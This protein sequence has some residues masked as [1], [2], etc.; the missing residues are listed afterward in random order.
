MHSITEHWANRLTIIAVVALPA[1]APRTEEQ[2]KG[3]AS[4]PLEKRRRPVLAVRAKFVQ[5]A[6]TSVARSGEENTV[7]IGAGGSAPTRAYIR[8]K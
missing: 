8:K 4:G 3:T 2:L 5:L 6:F 1:R 7:A